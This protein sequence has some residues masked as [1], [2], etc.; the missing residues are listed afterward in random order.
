MRDIAQELVPAHIK[1]DMDSKATLAAIKLFTTEADTLLLHTCLTEP[2][3]DSGY[4]SVLMF[5]SGGEGDNSWLLKWWSR[6]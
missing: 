5:E 2:H 6:A 4:D 3:A 1:D